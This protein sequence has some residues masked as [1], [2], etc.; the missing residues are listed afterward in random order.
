MKI[1]ENIVGQSEVVSILERA[2]QGSRKSE[3]EN[4]EMTHSWLFTG[5]SGSGKST[6]ANAFA[7]ALVCPNNGCANCVDCETAIN[8]SHLDIEILKTEGLSIKINE[9]RDLLSRS[10]TSPSV[11]NWRIILIHDIQRLTEAAVNALLKAVE[12]PSER[13][14]WILT[15]T[16]S[17]EVLPTIRSRCR[18]IQL[19]ILTKESIVKLLIEKHKVKSEIA[20]YSARV[21][22]GDLSRA[23]SISQNPEARVR[24]HQI[25]DLIFSIKD[26][27]TAF[28]VASRLNELVDE[29]VQLV[30][31]SLDHIELSQLQSSFQGS[32][33][34]LVTGGMKAI[35]DLE[36]NQKFRL[37]RLK[38]ELLD[39]LLLDIFSLFRDI[40]LIQMGE[41]ENLVNFEK[42]QLLLDFAKFNS[43]IEINEFIEQV[44]NAR[45]SLKESGSF[46]LILENLMNEI[47]KLVPKQ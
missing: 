25:I 4:Q 45:I 21:S 16:S 31:E 19:K 13:T 29:E 39:S 33:R 34:G 36:K 43:Y 44:T 3:G 1:F 12:E 7:A 32:G 30:T 2:I 9:V 14:I 18:N 37:T 15:A 20:E 26:S 27:S 38:Q 24:R 42:T 23:I 22:L 35:K 46:L 28:K 41:Q 6:T 8:G 11:S 5:P 40:M 47:I 10:A 17:V